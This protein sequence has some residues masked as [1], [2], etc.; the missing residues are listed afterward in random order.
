MGGHAIFIS[1]TDAG[2]GPSGQPGDY[3]VEEAT[4]TSGRW[5]G[6]KPWVGVSLA[7]PRRSYDH[8]GGGGAVRSKAV[9]GSI[10]LEVVKKLR[11][12]RG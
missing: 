7:K 12:Y 2:T 1:T 5:H 3:G 6:A 8:I 9:R 11:L 10:S 4:I